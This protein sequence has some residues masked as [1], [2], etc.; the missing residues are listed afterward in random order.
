MKNLTPKQV[1][2][3]ASL[4]ISLTTLFL[5]LFFQYSS[6]SFSLPWYLL[7]GL[8]I[9]VFGIGFFTFLY[10]IEIFIYRKIKLIYKTI[11][12][13]K[14]EKEDTQYINVLSDDTFQAVENEVRQWAENR[15]AEIRDLQEMEKYRKEFLGNVS[16][17]LKTPIFNIQG[18]LQTL[19]DGGIDDEQ[20]NRNYLAKANRN[21]E[22]LEAIVNDLEFIS[23]FE[24]GVLQL[25]QENFDICDLIREVFDSMEMQ[26]EVFDIRLSIKTGCE[27]SRP[28]FADRDRIRQ[29]LANLI[30]NSIK[31]GKD[32]GETKVSIYDM[33][34]NL[35]VEVTDNGIGIDEAHLKRIFERFYRVDKSRSR[36]QGG[37][38]LG[39]AIVK[40]I[41]E[42]HE[43]TI[44]TRSKPN[45]GTTIG[46]TLK[47]A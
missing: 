31:Y 11:H 23:K 2:L 15:V 29:V 7:A 8:P 14:A 37:T 30:S 38:G 5:L 13:L 32:G 25:E 3:L 36:N 28:V 21:V 33:D 1:A 6:S 17:E 12:N 19:E 9:A 47:K 26:A 44:N 24:S 22:R 46:F 18:Y 35:L 40:H 4:A 20:I 10:A 43:Q 34:E 39:L 41:I 16:H 45:L 42:A 27:T